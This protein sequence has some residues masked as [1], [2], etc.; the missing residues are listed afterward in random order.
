MR[1]R[2]GGVVR[3]SGAPL[4]GRAGGAHHT[5]T[6]T[7]LLL[8]LL[9]PATFGATI[10]SALTGRIMSEGKP[11][12]GATVTAT[13][14]AL[15]HP[16]VSRTGSYGT[17]WLAAMPPGVYEVTFAAKGK[18]TMTRRAT[19]ELGRIAR[20]D[21]VLEP[22]EDEENVTSTAKTV[23]AGDTTAITTYFSDWL[24]DRLPTRRD[25][26]AAGAIA[27]GTLNIFPVIDG[28]IDIDS[29][30][31]FGEEMLEQITV[32]RGA[33]PIEQHRS[34]GGTVDV[35][36]R[37]GSNDHFFSLRDSI[38]SASWIEG[39]PYG[40]G[41]GLDHFVEAAGG[42]R[43]VRDRLWF[44]GSAWSGDDAFSPGDSRGFAV[45][46]TSQIGASHNLIG[47]YVDADRESDLIQGRIEKSLLALQYTGALS[48]RLTVEGTLSRTSDAAHFFGEGVRV[49]D[50]RD[51]LSAKATYVLPTWAG[52]HVLTAGGTIA[53][54]D[55]AG[56]TYDEDVIFVNDRWSY[57]RWII[58]AGVRRQTFG[59]HTL[60][61]AA[62]VYDLRGN[63]RHA[64]I[65]TFT[66]YS[67]PELGYVLTENTIGYAAAL[68]SSGSFRADVIRA[69]SNA[70]ERVS[71]QLDGSY[72]LFDRL[73]TGANYTA[74][75]RDE[76]NPRPRHTANGWITV[77]IPL[78][79][80]VLGVTFLQ[81]Y[82]SRF[83]ESG[84]STASTDLALRYRTPL[85]RTMLTLAADVT[86][87]FNDSDMFRHLPRALR[88]W[89]RVSL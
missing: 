35:Q 84:E 81:R 51:S 42:G 36:T 80:R 19:I 40:G 34:I 78:G 15:Q 5:A 73:E 50:D 82:Q 49:R 20:A 86:N 43:F 8:L 83:R 64:A 59:D 32:F 33:V 13:S 1:L 11:V 29:S 87:V 21:A 62:L 38:T 48:P 61:R 75:L 24:L 77:D 28:S 25:P 66:R 52:D 16:R 56:G 63:R 2:V 57:S 9:A 46:L 88:L 45:K 70:I 68:G 53:S 60:P 72:R 23:S 10:T 58:E 26:I 18:Q 6:L 37:S 67:D 22:S 12:A 55:F 47:T 17:Y 79:E 7:L 3:A 65:A 4:K 41:S 89:A 85:G 30:L 39:A 74:A 76:L 14:S 44:F 71:L 27:A 69:E 54:T 31:L